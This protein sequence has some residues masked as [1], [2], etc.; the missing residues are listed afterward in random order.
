MVV[1]E[2]DNDNENNLFGF[3]DQHRLSPS[4]VGFFPPSPLLFFRL[5]FSGFFFDTN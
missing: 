1:Y 2:L 3:A 5:D 4:D